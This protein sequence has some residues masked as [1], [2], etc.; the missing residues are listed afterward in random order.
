M[1]MTD[2]KRMSALCLALVDPLPTDMAAVAEW[3]MTQVQGLD[4][5]VESE[6]T[7]ENHSDIRHEFHIGRQNVRA[8]ENLSRVEPLS[9]E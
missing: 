1:Q 9:G 2:E 5:I 7:L 3:Y 6:K 8:K 4:S